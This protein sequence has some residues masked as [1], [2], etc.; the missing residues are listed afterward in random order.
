MTGPH[1]CAE[2]TGLISRAATEVAG[3]TG[4]VAAVEVVEAAVTAGAT[5]DAAAA[6]DED[7][8]A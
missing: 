2:V 6:R 3:E 4:R 1:R 5:G 8:G 7:G